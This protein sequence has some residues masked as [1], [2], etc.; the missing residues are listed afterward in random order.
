MAN[1][2][3]PMGIARTCPRFDEEFPHWL[4]MGMGNPLLFQLGMGMVMGMYISP[5]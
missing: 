5:L 3:V 2:P 4:V 1:K